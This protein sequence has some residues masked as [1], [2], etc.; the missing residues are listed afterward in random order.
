MSSNSGTPK[1]EVSPQAFAVLSRQAQKRQ[2]KA[3]LEEASNAEK[4]G[5]FDE[6]LALVD[7]AIKLDGEA[8]WFLVR[9][10]E[11][12]DHAGK[13]VESIS[14]LQ[15]A[16][17]EHPTSNNIR[18]HYATRLFKQGRELEALDLLDKAISAEKSN[19]MLYVRKSEL[20]AARGRQSESIKSARMAVTIS[21]KS[22]VARASLAQLLCNAGQYNEGLEHISKAIEAEP[23]NAGFLIVKSRL[24]E[25]FG[26]FNDSVDTAKM[27]VRAAAG[28]AYAKAHLANLLA[29][30]GDLESALKLIDAAIAADGE[31]EAYKLRKKDYAARLQKGLAETKAAQKQPLSGNADCVS[32][33]NNAAL[34]GQPSNPTVAPS[35]LTQSVNKAWNKF[36]KNAPDKI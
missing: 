1:E 6:A 28:N 16:L 5:R 36:R 31:T 33:E 30:T 23:M 24:L 4:K 29:Q 2:A 14:V 35:G 22:A 18:V 20:L 9:K 34:S 11:I 10:S 26:K 3:K 19:S 15:K 25:A 32:I 17:S 12:L 21:P 27:A 7:A 13:S 8:L